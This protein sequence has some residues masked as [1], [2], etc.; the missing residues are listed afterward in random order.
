MFFFVGDTEPVSVIEELYHIDGMWRSRVALTSRD[1]EKIYLDN[2]LPDGVQMSPGVLTSGNV[3][4]EGLENSLNMYVES[5]KVRWEG[6]S[7]S[8]DGFGYD[9]IDTATKKR[10]ITYGDIRTIEGLFSVF[11]ETGHAWNDEAGLPG[12]FSGGETRGEYFRSSIKRF[13]DRFLGKK[14]GKTAIENNMLEE[15]DASAHALRVIRLLRDQGFKMRDIAS[16]PVKDFVEKC[17]NS[18]Q[19]REKSWGNFEKI[20]PRRNF[21]SGIRKNTQ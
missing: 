9:A 19:E 15:R 5:T 10:G 11:H 21:I 14:Y 1:G 3:S 2:L 4:Q 13:S 7:F 17:L 18:Y 6:D 16:V 12:T 8:N 20:K